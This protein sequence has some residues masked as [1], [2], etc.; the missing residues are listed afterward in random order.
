MK[1]N[2]IILS[3]IQMKQHTVLHS[4]RHDL[5]AER[6]GLDYIHVVVADMRRV[7]LDKCLEAKC[8]EKTLVELEISPEPSYGT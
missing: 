4:S 3:S 6:V 8:H 5:K 7:F 1:I 2:M